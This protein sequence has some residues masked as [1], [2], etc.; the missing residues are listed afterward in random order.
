MAKCQTPKEIK[1]DKSDM[2]ARCVQDC[3]EFED[4]RKCK[5]CLNFHRPQ[6]MFSKVAGQM[7]FTCA[8]E[9]ELEILEKLNGA[10]H[11]A[12]P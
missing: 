9:Y 10:V 7:C 11:E 3:G 5:T 8:N 4:M 6:N 1:A 12:R 2:C